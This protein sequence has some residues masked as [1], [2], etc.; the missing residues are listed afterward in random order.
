MSD[1]ERT[2]SPAPARRS[3]GGADQQA[4]K[5]LLR[6]GL[7][8]AMREHLRHSDWSSVTMTD[9]AEAAGVSR[10]TVYNEFGS[11]QGLA[12]AYAL[13][14]TDEFCGAVDAAV[15]K[16]VGRVRDAL[17]EAYRTFFGLAAA[18]PLVQ[19][20]LSGQ[21]KPDLLRL[22]TTDAAPLILHAT[23]RLATTLHRSWIG[24]P[25]DEARRVASSIGRMALSYIAMPPEDDSDV[26]DHLAR[27]FEPV[28]ASVARSVA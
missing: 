1:P 8:D 14:L 6:G 2:A 10:Q 26:A 27:L 28:I 9:I 18:D 12:T 3:R 5:Q 24:A 20:L 7:L 22:I 15:E 17:R 21:A 19:S 16:N 4:S 25:H 11:R 13:R 23:E